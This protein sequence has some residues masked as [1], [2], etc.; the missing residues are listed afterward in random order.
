[1]VRKAW[2]LLLVIV[3]LAAAV[4]PLS[5]CGSEDTT[6][7]LDGILSSLVD[8]EGRGEAESLAQSASVDLV[9]GAVKVVI[10]SRSGQ[11]EAVEKAAA[12][13]GTVVIVSERLE[14]VAALIP[15]ANLTALAREKGVL[16]IRQP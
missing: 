8:A 3:L 14:L 1:M 13:Y 11:L 16:F 9:D 4:F 7:K 5:G 15:I 10:E 6:Y 12:K 2:H